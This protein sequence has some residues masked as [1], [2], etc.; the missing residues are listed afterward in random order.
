MANP[1]DALPTAYRLQILRALETVGPQLPLLETVNSSLMLKG[2]FSYFMYQMAHY[3]NGYTGVKFLYGAIEFTLRWSNPAWDIFCKVFAEES[4][5]IARLF[6]TL[7]SALA[8][9]WLWE[10]FSA[11][12]IKGSS[13]QLDSRYAMVVKYGSAFVR[14]AKSWWPW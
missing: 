11:E 8:A 6:A 12:D 9:P 5:I 14:F 7:S 4:E 13:V 1:M 10:P 3:G 2:S